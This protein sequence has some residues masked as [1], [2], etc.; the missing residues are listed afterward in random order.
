MA[1]SILVLSGPSGCGKSSLVSEILKVYHDIYFSISTTTR[2]IR[3]GEEEG[4]NYHYISKEQFEKEI[5]EGEFLEYAKVHDN[6]YGTSLKPVKKAL[7]EGKLVIFDIDVQG[8]E[9]V[10]KE[11]G[12]ILTSLFITTPTSDVLRA[13]LLGRGT[14]SMDVIERRL[15]NSRTEMDRIDEYDFLLINDVFEQTLEKFR[16]IVEV[17]RMKIDKKSKD[18]FIN[19]WY[20]SL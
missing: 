11:F 3:E 12:D 20:N 15:K 16:A 1:G 17:S 6:Y 19:S 13:R 10:K 9:I 8:H 14:D 4:L 7:S 5:E 2:V 18:N